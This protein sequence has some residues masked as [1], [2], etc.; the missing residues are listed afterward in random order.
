MSLLDLLEKKKGKR[1]QMKNFMNIS[2]KTVPIYEK[3]VMLVVIRISRLFSAYTIKRKR[4]FLVLTYVD[5]D[6]L[7]DNYSFLEIQL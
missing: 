5:Q 1:L 3:L 4:S 2:D 6:C 7:K